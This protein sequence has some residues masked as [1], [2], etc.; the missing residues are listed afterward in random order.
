MH[1]DYIQKKLSNFSKFNNLHFL[2]AGDIWVDV[3]ILMI[4]SRL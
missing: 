3:A 2:E 1:I 4:S